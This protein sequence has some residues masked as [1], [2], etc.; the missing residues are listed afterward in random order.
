MGLLC[1]ESL[2]D[3][4][5]LEVQVLQVLNLAEEV[6]AAVAAVKKLWVLLLVWLHVLMPPLLGMGV[7]SPMALQPSIA[8]ANSS[9]I[10]ACL[11]C[12]CTGC[13]Y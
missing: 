13:S 6:R 11:L 7:D 3:D 5:I 8:Q 4:G 1:V 10:V 9:P 12:C 2:I